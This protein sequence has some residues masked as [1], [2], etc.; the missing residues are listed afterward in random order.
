MNR[1]MLWIVAFVI[2]AAPVLADLCRLDCERQRQPECPLHQQTPHQCGH[3]H[4]AVSYDRVRASA[5]SIRPIFLAIVV[6]PA[7]VD[8]APTACHLFR[9][10]RQHAPP[11]R[12]P[13]TDV[14]RI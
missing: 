2:A 7:R 6:T 14:L 9:A 12:S 8:D 5:D 11:L 13:H 10:G 3:D 4:A 1:L